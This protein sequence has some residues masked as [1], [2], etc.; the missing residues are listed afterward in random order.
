MKNIAYLVALLFFST[1]IAQD[2]PTE[3]K[4]EVEIKTLNYKNNDT[5]KESKVKVI[6]RETSRV[7]LDE[8]D[9]NKVN[10]D[11]ISETKKV[12]KMVLIDNDTDNDYDFLTKE[13][14]YISEN[15]NYKFT[16]NKK[17]FNIAFNNNTNQFVK[18]GKAWITSAIGNY[19]VRGKTE[20]GI[21]FFDKDGN[22]VVEYYDKN[23]KDIKTK[24][25]NK[26]THNLQ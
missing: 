17:G 8:S 25:Y 22:F 1:A 4:E 12:E 15:K 13:T 11:R 23:S 16:P 18:I 7:K 14:L 20:N 3:I 2:N 19:I 10:Q 26:D 6:T 5:Y 24:K 9:A 21:G